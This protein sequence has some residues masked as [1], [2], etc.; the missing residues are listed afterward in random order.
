MTDTK[1][2]EKHLKGYS[3]AKLIQL[4]LELYREIDNAKSR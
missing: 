2:L 4:C 1:N 3:K